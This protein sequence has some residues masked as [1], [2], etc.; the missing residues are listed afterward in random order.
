[1]STAFFDHRPT[2]LPFHPFD[3]VL[4]V[5]QALAEFASSK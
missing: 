1:M 3:Q 4:V 5:E 2:C